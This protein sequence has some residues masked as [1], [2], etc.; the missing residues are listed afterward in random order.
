MLPVSSTVQRTLMTPF[1]S[2]QSALIPYSLIHR[3]DIEITTPTT[4]TRFILHWGADS[5]SKKKKN[6]S[7]ATLHSPALMGRISNPTPNGN[8]FITNRFIGS[9]GSNFAGSLSYDL[10]GIVPSPW[11]V[12]VVREEGA[13]EST[14]NKWGS[15]NEAN[16][17]KCD[18]TTKQVF[19]AIGNS[20]PFFR[21]LVWS[22]TGRP[23]RRFG[24]S[25]LSFAIV[26]TLMTGFSRDSSSV[27]H[28][29]ST[30]S[31]P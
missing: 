16:R 10:S 12:S 25:L 11:C 9:V 19:F 21:A 1:C 17:E 24:G 22:P 2:L 3:P 13:A 26:M 27:L 8:Y 15:N 7:T 6:T 5:R 23:D 29:S 18:L 31:V 4:P 28:Q 30:H 20:L 14:T